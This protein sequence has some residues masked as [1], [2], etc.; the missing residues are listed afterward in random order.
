MLIMGTLRVEEDEAAVRRHYPA[1]LCIQHLPGVATSAET[2]SGVS[3]TY[4][5]GLYGIIPL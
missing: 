2:R 1:H 5:Q 4:L 3:S